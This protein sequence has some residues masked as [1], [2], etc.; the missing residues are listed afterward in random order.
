MLVK[1]EQLFV[2]NESVDW[3]NAGEGV[4][5]K[6]MAYGDQLMAVI[7][8]FKKDSVGSLHHHPHLQ[9]TYI[10]KGSLT[11]HIGAESKVLRAGDFYYIPANVVHG[12]EAYED[13]ILIDFFTPMREDFISVT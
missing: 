5:R 12:V 9:I 2:E 13:S 3:E 1:K 6:V 8:E 7:V 11:V 10:E 4:R